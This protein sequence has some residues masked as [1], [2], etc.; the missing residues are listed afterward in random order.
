MEL[1]ERLRGCTG[2]QWDEG[3]ANKNWKK[4]RVTQSESEAIF[5]C[6]PLVVADDIA[7]A[8]AEE[9]FFALG[10]TK[11]A[12][13]LFVVFGIRRRKIR[14]ISARDMTKKER[15]VYRFHG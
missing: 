8:D 3:N 9:R 5:F 2:F 12:R 1:L 13:L 15:E 4:H 7:H 10:H 11:R 6:Q 14:V